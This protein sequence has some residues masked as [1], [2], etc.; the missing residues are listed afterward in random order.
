MA[1]TATTSLAVPLAPTWKIWAVKV[2]SSSL[3]PLKAEVVARRS[4]STTR[5]AASL[6]SE[7]R[8]DELLVPLAACTASSRMRCRLLEICAKSPSAVCAREMPSLALRAAWLEPRI[9]EVK[10]S[11]M[12]KPAASSLALL[13]RRPEDSRAMAVACEVSETLSC[14]CAVNELMLVLMKEGITNSDNS[15]LDQCGTAAALN[16]SPKVGLPATARCSPGHRLSD[17]E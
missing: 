13:M 12:A 3:M 4:F 7:T 5:A 2:P 15:K 6:L 9:C 11:E 14:R 1:L 16:A 17:L 10:R 8:S